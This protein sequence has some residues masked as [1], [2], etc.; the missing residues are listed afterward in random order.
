MGD[1]FREQCGTGVE[2]YVAG[3]REID[4]EDVLHWSACGMD[5]IGIHQR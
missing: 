5:W 2:V 4:Q 3:A 1:F